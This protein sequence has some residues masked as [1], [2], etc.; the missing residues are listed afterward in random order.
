MIRGFTKWIWVAVI[1]GL[2]IAVAPAALQRC[3]TRIESDTVVRWRKMR[4]E[5]PSVRVER[6]N[7][8][9]RVLIPSEADTS[10]VAAL[11]HE[12]D[13]LREEL[14]AMGVQERLTLD[15]VT[16]DGD[17]ITASA[18]CIH[19]TISVRADFAARTVVVPETTIVNTVVR[20]GGISL[21]V[22]IGAA[23]TLGTTAA[24]A[25]AVYI[26]IGGSYDLFNF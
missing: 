1:V 12:R 15:T 8:P 10:L 25:P 4:V 19:R 20:S 18:D 24:L 6:V 9:V 14:A 26:G 11:T 2:L 5:V 3:G 16:A 23:V 21:H 17:T 22:G 7:V 13:S